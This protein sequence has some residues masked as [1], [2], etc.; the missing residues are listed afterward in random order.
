M[1]SKNLPIEDWTDEQKRLGI[2]QIHV[3]RLRTAPSGR[4]RNGASITIH[5]TDCEGL[6]DAAR[7]A[8]VEIG[9][10]TMGTPTEGT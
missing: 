7:K 6:F 3:Q 5:A 2:V 10:P 1:A 9:L 4:I 8:A